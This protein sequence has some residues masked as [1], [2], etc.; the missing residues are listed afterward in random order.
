MAVDIVA[1]D[2]ASYRISQDPKL[3][4][5][6]E[7]YGYDP[8][9][10]YENKAGSKLM[11]S[12]Q[13]SCIVGEMAHRHKACGELWVLINRAWDMGCDQWTSADAMFIINALKAAP[14]D[15]RWEERTKPET[16]DWAHGLPYEEYLK[17]SHW[18]D[19]VRPAALERAGHKCQLCG[20]RDAT[21]HVH[22]NT[23]ENLGHELPADIVVLCENCHR[24]FHYSPVDTSGEG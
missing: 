3:Q 15:P 17:T 5:L 10:R 12:A 1:L 20:G 4:A 19:D 21:L 23:Y 14:V 11:S 18:R 22:H 9:R 2:R 13:R 6:A 7:K 24:R 8:R 16:E